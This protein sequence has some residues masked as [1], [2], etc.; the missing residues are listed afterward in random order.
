MLIQVERAIVES[1]KKITNV[2]Y[3]KDCYE[4]QQ[5]IDQL[6]E[7][8]ER[9]RARLN[10][11]IRSQNALHDNPHTPSSKVIFK[12]NIKKEKSRPGAK[13]GH[14]GNKR[15]PP[16]KATADHYCRIEMPTV[17]PDCHEDLTQ[18][19]SRRRHVIDLMQEQLQTIFYDIARAHCYNCHKTYR[20]PIPA[21]ERG[22]LGNNLL[23]NATV[24][25]YFDNITMGKVTDLYDGEINLS[26]FINSFHRLYKIFEPAY[27]HLVETYRKTIVKHADETGWRTNGKN[28]YAWIFCSKYTS[29]FDFADNRSGK[30]VTKIMGKDPLPGFL[31]VDRY[32][33]YNR[34]GCKLQYCYAHL[35]REVER[36]K[37]DYPY[38]GEVTDFVDQFATALSETMRLKYMPIDD[39]CYYENAQAL[40]QRIE[41]I[42]FAP[43]KNE[44]VL[45]IKKIFQEKSERLY[46]W[47][48]NREVPSHNNFAERMIRSTVIA[49]KVSLGSYSEK[50]R[51]TR[52]LLMSILTT[53]HSR[54]GHS[55]YKLLTWFKDTLDHISATKQYSNDLLPPIPDN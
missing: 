8:V 13:P 47:A 4:K 42:A 19:S 22:V 36:L 25:H 5:K 32:A 23:A 53:A 41:S 44:G 18:V 48:D 49:R 35:L 16:D 33:A 3:C 38:N 46:H 40:K 27:D 26:T 11:R 45:R 7:E 52:S 21:L 55:R 24:L 50:G 1:G 51:N 30:I 14:K 6:K 12:P 43:A 2:V 28:G 39:I 54:L 31:V 17:C 37:K 29:I 34:A 20:N 15:K 10:G 9:L